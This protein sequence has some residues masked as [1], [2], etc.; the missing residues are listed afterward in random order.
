MDPP[1]TET[2][3]ATPVSAG[4][5]AATAN[6]PIARGYTDLILNLK[7]AFTPFELPPVERVIEAV[8]TTFITENRLTVLPYRGGGLGLYRVILST[9]IPD[10]SEHS[11]SFQ[12]LDRS[13]INVGYTENI[14][15][16]KGGGYPSNRRSG[17]LVTFV[18]A[19]VGDLAHATNEAFDEA[20]GTFGTLGNPRYIWQSVLCG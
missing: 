11:A 3:P 19:A 18:Q 17:T 5:A 16:S 20:V 6:A 1:T 14:R 9:P 4:V 12:G 7:D 10:L 13:A 2:S 15:P 8:S